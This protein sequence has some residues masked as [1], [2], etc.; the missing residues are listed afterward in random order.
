MEYSADR[1]EFETYTK[2]L[3]PGPKQ[4]FWWLFWQKAHRINPQSIDERLRPL[5]NFSG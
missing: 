4:G 1:C 3:Y 2:V 5:F